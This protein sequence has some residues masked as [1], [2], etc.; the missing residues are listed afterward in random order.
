MSNSELTMSMTK[1]T[2]YGIK[3]YFRGRQL[4]D[5]SEPPS[6]LIDDFLDIIISGI[7]CR[8]W[9]RERD[10]EA[11]HKHCNEYCAIETCVVMGQPFYKSVE[12]SL[13]T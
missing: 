11:E 4:D 3:F 2:V 6:N 10:T 9:D 7:A 1:T 5:D 13:K 8:D 12:D